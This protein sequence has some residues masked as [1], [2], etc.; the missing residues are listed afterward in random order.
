MKH[1]FKL[2]AVLI[3][4][5]AASPAFAQSHTVALS[6]TAS[7]DAAANPSLTY[8]I[9]R[10]NVPCASATTFSKVNTSAIAAVTFTDSGLQPGSYCYQGTAVLN[11]VESLASN[12]APAVILPKAQTSLV[13]VPN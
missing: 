7:T 12:Q 9:Y 2:L 8:N 1:M 13:A 5:A 4:F 10:A 11:G 3:I 6:W